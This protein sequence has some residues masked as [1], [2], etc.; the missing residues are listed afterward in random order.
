M[1]RID[2]KLELEETAL[3]LLDTTGAPAADACMVMGD[4]PE[5]EC[6]SWSSSITTLL[7]G[8]DMTLSSSQSCDALAVL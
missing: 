5:N 7:L 1:M 3:A 6:S 8:L 2:E 4:V